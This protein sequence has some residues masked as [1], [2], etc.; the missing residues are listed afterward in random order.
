MIVPT[1]EI[2]KILKGLKA[3][4][5]DN[6]VCKLRPEEAQIL[7]DYIT[8]LQIE[9]K[10]CFREMTKLSLYKEMYLSQCKKDKVEKLYG[11]IDP[12]RRTTTIPDNETL[13]YK[14][15]E[16]IDKVNQLQR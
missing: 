7:L 4:S 1:N 13:M 10:S 12:A 15:N 14:I 8:D 16:I 9:A 6:L 2:E 11:T 5:D 3:L